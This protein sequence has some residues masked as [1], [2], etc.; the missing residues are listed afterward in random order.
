M[1]GRTA[2]RFRGPNKLCSDTV[3]STLVN[4]W[5]WDKEPDVLTFLESCFRAELVQSY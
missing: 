3:G 4:G 2:P 1:S 5:N